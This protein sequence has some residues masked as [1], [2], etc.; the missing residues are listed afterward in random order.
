MTGPAQIHSI[1]PGLRFQEGNGNALLVAAARRD[2]L[3]PIK[4]LSLTR[5]P[6]SECSDPTARIWQLW[7]IQ[8]AVACGDAPALGPTQ[9]Q[10]FLAPPSQI[11]VVATT[12]DVEGQ[13]VSTLGGHY[14]LDDRE[15]AVEL[16]FDRSF[17]RG[18]GLH[19]LSVIYRL[20]VTALS[21]VLD[22]RDRE[23]VPTYAA[24]LPSNGPS[25][26]SFIRSGSFEFADVPDCLAAATE[27]RQ[28]VLYSHSPLGAQAE[29]VRG[30][31]YAVFPP[32]AVL[33]GFDAMLAIIEAGCWSTGREVVPLSIELG[34]L[35]N[36]RIAK[37]LRAD[38]EIMVKVQ[39]RLLARLQCYRQAVR[40]PRA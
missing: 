4:H 23:I 25:R 35:G 28:G 19:R 11:I 29:A 12:F 10:R 2:K 21:F 13:D 30:V 22:G 20:Y 18:I 27:G 14:A 5:V 34:E 8:E 16:A 6:A 31:L 17:V 7:G 26:R 1:R 33:A 9:L 36:P 24:V 40:Q 37:R 39:T 32:A 3:P 15:T 38:I